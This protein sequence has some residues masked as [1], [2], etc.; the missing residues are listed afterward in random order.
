MKRP[1][2]AETE[3]GPMKNTIQYQDGKGQT[4]EKTLE[5]ATGKQRQSFYDGLDP[6]FKDM[7]GKKK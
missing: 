2:E 6:V 3:A 1:S 5:Y 4:K 7:G